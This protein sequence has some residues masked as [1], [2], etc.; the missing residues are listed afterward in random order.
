MFLWRKIKLPEDE[1]YP[2]EIAKITHRRDYFHNKRKN[3][4]SRY[5]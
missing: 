4:K 2:N 5:G 3:R 1:F